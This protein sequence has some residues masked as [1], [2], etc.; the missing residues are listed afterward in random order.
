MN[1]AWIDGLQTMMLQYTSIYADE[2]GVTH[3]RER[4][5]DLHETLI[6]PLIPPL[7]ATSPAEASS[8]Y[9]L[10]FPP[11]ISMDWHP[12]PKRLFHFFLAGEC[13]VAVSD[14]TVR[15]FQTGDIVLAEDTSGT[16]HMTSNP[17]TVETLMAVVA[18]PE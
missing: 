6:G 4:E 3:F 2:N 8:Y 13:R 16:G 18:L 1:L 9:F 14:G 5:L 11:G 7:G 17:G 12:A 10:T 15:S